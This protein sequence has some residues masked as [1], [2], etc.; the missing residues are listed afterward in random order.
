M[1]CDLAQQDLRDD[2]RA[3]LARADV[4]QALLYQRGLEA[5]IADQ[6]QCEEAVKLRQHGV[7]QQRHAAVGGVEIQL[8]RQQPIELHRD[9]MRHLAL[10]RSEEHTSELQSLM[11]N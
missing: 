5:R 2:A 4:E 9:V 10:L 7:A 3:Q 6:A 1:P 8:V 11:R